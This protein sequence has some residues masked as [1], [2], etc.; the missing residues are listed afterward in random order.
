MSLANGFCENVVNMAEI[1]LAP[2]KSRGQDH[3]IA[4]ICNDE[5]VTYRQLWSRVNQAGNAFLGLE[6]TT[7]DRVVLM[8]RDT[9]AFFYVYLG[10]MTI[11]AVPIAI[12]LRLS[13]AD[14]AY[15][16]NDSQAKAIVLDDIFFKDYQ[17]YILFHRAQRYLAQQPHPAR[18]PL[19][20]YTY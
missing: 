17:G 15:T 3:D 13:N 9:P 11:G 6:I 12:N 16:M 19:L 1:I 18:I 4:L 7:G 5:M 20:E 14:V 8:V 10:L 2:S